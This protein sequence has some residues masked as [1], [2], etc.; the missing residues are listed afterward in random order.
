TSPVVLS[1]PFGVIQRF[2]WETSPVRRIDRIEL[3]YQSHRTVTSGLK[4]RKDLKELDPDPPEET[5]GAAGAA[6]A[7]GAP[8]AAGPPTASP[9]P[10]PGMGGKGGGSMEGGP[11]GAA[12]SGDVTRINKIDRARYLHVTDQCRHLPI[13][14]R[15]VLDQAHIGDFLTAVAN[16]RLR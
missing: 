12:A 8:G 4:I 15:V 14:V 13:G 6:G 16:S 11:S 1:K 10:T 2:E 9:P 5:G 7:P 3:A